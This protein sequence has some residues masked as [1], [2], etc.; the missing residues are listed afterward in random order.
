MRDLQYL[1]SDVRESTDNTDTNGIKDKEIIRY[2]QDGVRSIQAI[3]FKNNP[4]CSYFQY[5]TI[6][7]APKSGTAYALPT[8]TYADNAVTFVETQSDSGSSQFWTRLDR[9]WQ[10]D[11][12]IRMGWYTRNR[13]ILFSGAQDSPLSLKARAWYFRRLP[14]WDKVW[15]K[16]TSIAG[17]T[18][19]ISVTDRDFVGVDSI[20][21]FLDTSGNQKLGTDGLPILTGLKF[22]LVAPF[23]FDASQ[24]SI[25]TLLVLGTLTG[26][27]VGD[28]IVMGKNTTLSID[29]PEEVE[30]YILDYVGKRIYSRNNYSLDSAKVEYFTQEA[31]DNI[32]QIF[33]D[34]GQSQVT[35]PI[36]DTDFLGI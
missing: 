32:V 18:I 35:T 9:C 3:I 36:T 34:V 23:S 6:I 25:G 12:N 11:Q 17:N 33:T 26:L 16:V 21:T 28:Q 14:R 5:P 22:S 1:I 15:A 31:R 2:F 24:N 4:L 19:A 8:D 29:L 27:A 13:S 10:E 7:T 30:S 20:L